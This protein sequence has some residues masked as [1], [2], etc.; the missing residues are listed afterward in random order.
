MTEEEARTYQIQYLNTLPDTSSG[1]VAIEV[2][3]DFDRGP[4]GEVAEVQEGICE[5]QEGQNGSQ[6]VQNVQNIQKVQNVQSIEVQNIEVEVQNIQQVLNIQEVGFEAENEPLQIQGDI[7]EAESGICGFVRDI[8]G[9]QSVQNV[10]QNVMLGANSPRP[11]IDSSTGK[12]VDKQ[13]ITIS[14]FKTLFYGKP[15][16]RKIVKKRERKV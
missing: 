5:V 6:S 10:Q 7:E 14:S 12:G 4:E 9:S 13:S 8:E 2:Q 15:K 11:E 1:E 16:P 3:N